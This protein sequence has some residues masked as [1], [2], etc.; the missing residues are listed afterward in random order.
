MSRQNEANLVHVG[1][2]FRIRED[3]LDTDF[4]ELIQEIAKRYERSAELRGRHQIGSAAH[5]LAFGRTF[6]VNEL[7][8]ILQ[9][10]TV[11]TSMGDSTVASAST[12][13]FAL[14]DR[15]LDEAEAAL[16]A[17]TAS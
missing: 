8:N 16:P 10:P 11:R 1:A 3:L 6:L 15:I 5:E 17:E 2:G 9:N 4:G 14:V 13:I 12:D 7:L